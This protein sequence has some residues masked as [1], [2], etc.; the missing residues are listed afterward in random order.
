MVLLSRDGSEEMLAEMEINWQQLVRYNGVD[1]PDEFS[2]Y[3]AVIGVNDGENDRYM[4][5]TTLHEYK[6]YNVLNLIKNVL[7]QLTEDQL[8]LKGPIGEETDS[9]NMARGLGRVGFEVQRWSDRLRDYRSSLRGR[10]PIEPG[11]DT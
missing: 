6:S 3:L 4:S 7:M 1:C 10:Q 2:E 9:P 11:D 5:V 8:E